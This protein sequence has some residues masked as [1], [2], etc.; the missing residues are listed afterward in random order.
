MVTLGRAGIGAEEVKRGPVGKHHRIAFQL[1]LHF[2]GEV[3]DVLF[4][5]VGLCLT[6]GKENLVTSGKQGVN[7]TY[8]NRSN[9]ERAA[10]MQWERLQR[11]VASFSLQLAE[12]RADLY[13]EMPVKVS[14]F[15]QPIDDAEWTITTLTHTVSP[16]NGFTT[17]L[18]LEVRIDDFEME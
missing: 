8:A 14:G 12:G 16:D 18:E 6:G 9:A 1:H 11:G 2:F 13:T 17:S 5:D 7:R 4:K 10:K 15:K 3:D